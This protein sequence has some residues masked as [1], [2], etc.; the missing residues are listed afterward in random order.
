M[1]IIPQTKIRLLKVPLTLDNKNQL[2]FTNKDV[3]YNY[4]NSLPKLIEDNATYLRKDGVIRFNA[5]FDDI[6]QYNY[7]MYQNESY[8]DKWFYAFITGMEYKGNDV[9]FI[10]I[11]T[12]VW[13]TW[14]FDVIFKQSFVER[15]MINVEDDKP[16]NNLMPEGL[17][18][19]EY[20]IDQFTKVTELEP[21][22]IVA[23]S[24]SD[25]FGYS[26]NGIY[27]RY[28]ILWV[29]IT[30]FITCLAC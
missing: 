8:S 26:Y 11:E 5:N 24:K 19:G 28:S 30:K 20:T 7:V 21:W 25:E 3:Q 14:Q 27:S 2:T 4:F 16:G 29:F 23:Y 12:D 13:Q 15:E 18:T 6:L 1:V 17:E 22:Y 9:T 10:S